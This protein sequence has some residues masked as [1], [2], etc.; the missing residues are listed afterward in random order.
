MLLAIIKK[1]QKMTHKD[2]FLDQAA[3]FDAGLEPSHIIGVFA[4][5]LLV[6]VMCA[7]LGL[8]KIMWGLLL[9]YSLD[10]RGQE[11][12]GDGADG[13]EDCGEGAQELQGN[14]NRTT[15]KK[16]SAAAD[17]NYGNYEHDGRA[18]THDVHLLT[19]VFEK[20]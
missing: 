13:R 19:H 1:R 18:G 16:E 8:K 9:L 6:M 5:P 15:E 20:T 12:Q 11:C 7:L 14:F 10:N 4:L 17:S 3:I 2:A